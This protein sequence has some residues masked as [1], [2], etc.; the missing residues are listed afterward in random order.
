MCIQQPWRQ[1]CELVNAGLLGALAKRSDPRASP[2]CFLGPIGVVNGC[3]RILNIPVFIP[4]SHSNVLY[5]LHAPA[6]LP[7][8]AHAK[9]AAQFT[10]RTQLNCY[11]SKAPHACV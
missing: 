8:V 7:P 3:L 9:H 10:A 11:D 6:N 5:E 4:Q 2:Q 1:L